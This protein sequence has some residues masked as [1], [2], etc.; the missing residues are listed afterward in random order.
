MT[1]QLEA[2]HMVLNVH[3]IDKMIDFYTTVLGFEVTDRGPLRA[4]TNGTGEIVFLSQIANHHHQ[5]AF[6]SGRA[7]PEASNNTHHV[8]YRSRGTLADLKA[9]LAKLEANG[10]VTAIMPLT[11]GNAWS[12]YF[13]DPEFNGLEVFIDTPWHVQQ[14]QGEPLNLKASDEEI[15]SATEATFRDRNQFGPIDEFYAN[16]AEYLASKG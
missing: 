15:F 13:R 4:A 12:I 1:L 8:A 5:V 10:E 2:A 16:R 9:L 7:T 11:H 14:P 6:V 3:N